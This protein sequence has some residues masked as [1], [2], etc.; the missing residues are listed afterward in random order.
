[1]LDAIASP[2]MSVACRNACEY[3]PDLSLLGGISSV[4][5]VEVSPVGRKRRIISAVVADE[6][7]EAKLTTPVH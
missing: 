4:S 5:F 3:L 1:M 6:Y 2:P 7:L